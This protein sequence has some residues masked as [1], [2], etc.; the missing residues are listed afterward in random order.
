MKRTSIAAATLALVACSVAPLQRDQ[1]VELAP[2]Q[3]LAAVMFDALDPLT[4]VIIEGRHGPTLVID[5]VPVGRSI[6]LF[7]VPA[8]TYC[9]TRFRTGEWEFTGKRGELACF[10]VEAGKLSYS[11]TL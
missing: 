5:A 10:A 1:A 8:G 4:H 6:Y 11:G 3:G 9:F 2:G 7:P